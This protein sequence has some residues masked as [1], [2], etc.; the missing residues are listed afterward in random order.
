MTTT[1]RQTGGNTP[2]DGGGRWKRGRQK[3]LPTRGPVKWNSSHPPRAFSV[4]SMKTCIQTHPPNIPR[5]TQ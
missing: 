5:R 2:V 4:K 1:M 3:A